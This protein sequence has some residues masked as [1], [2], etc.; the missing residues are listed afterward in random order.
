MIMYHPVTLEKVHAIK[1]KSR[2]K[3]TVK[4]RAMRRPE[5]TLATSVW[6]LQIG[7][8]AIK[9]NFTDAKMKHVKLRLSEDRK[10]LYYQK[11]SQD[12]SL[13]DRIKGK[14]QLPLSSLI[15]IAYGGIT[16]TF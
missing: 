9:V 16:S 14:S 7:V 11:V 4:T 10:S 2:L 6:K 1:Q 13:L 15:G 5:H 12:R 3:N 8:Q